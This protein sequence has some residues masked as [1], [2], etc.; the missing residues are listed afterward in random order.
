M[1]VDVI[2]KKSMNT[3]DEFINGDYNKYYVS[4]RGMYI[5]NLEKRSTLAY[6]GSYNYGD[7][8]GELQ[9]AMLR[10]QIKQQNKANR[11]YHKRW[12]QGGVICKIGLKKR[13]YYMD[14]YLYE[15]QIL[16][17][18]ELASKINK[19]QKIVDTTTTQTKTERV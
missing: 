14:V 16:P 3:T 8:L 13:K 9:V 5:H 17:S 6:R 2:Y 12:N 4:Q 7:K 1:Y 10:D 18:Y 15:Q 11:N 19:I